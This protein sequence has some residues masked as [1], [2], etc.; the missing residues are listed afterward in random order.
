MALRR[1]GCC[2]AHRAA[3]QLLYVPYPQVRCLVSLIRFNVFGRVIAVRRDGDSWQAYAVGSDGK[4]GQA[5]IVVPDF[6]AEHELEQYLADIFHESARP[7]MSDVR[8]IS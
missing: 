2:N 5:G 8:R 6:I 1:V 4:L 7:G 3:R